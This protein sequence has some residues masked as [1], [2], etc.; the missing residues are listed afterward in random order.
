MLGEY[1]FK[2]NEAFKTIIRIML[3]YTL[4]QKEALAF[5]NACLQEKWNYTNEEIETIQEIISKLCSINPI[6]IISKKKQIE[7]ANIL[8]IKA[9]KYLSDKGMGS[10]FV[11]DKKNTTNDELKLDE[12]KDFNDCLKYIQKNT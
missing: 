10:V 3:A 6:S 9:D 12:L 1:T 7:L 11:R 8:I 5:L 2:R 4:S